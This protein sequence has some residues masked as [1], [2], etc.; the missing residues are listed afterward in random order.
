[1]A[2]CSIACDLHDY[3]EV[4]C[5]Y[6]YRLK[7]TLKDSQV[8]EGKAIDIVTIEKREFLVIDKGEKQQIELNRLKKLTVLTANS[9]FTE[10]IF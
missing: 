9:Q 4:A 5:L 10:V 2:E 3:L 6:G 8:I 1:M 7:L